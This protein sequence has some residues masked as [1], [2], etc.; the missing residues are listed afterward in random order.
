MNFVGIC[1]LCIF[2]A[3]TITLFKQYNPAFAVALASL[4]AAV[5]MLI[6][7]IYFK[8]VIEQVIDKSSY[9]EQFSDFLSS[10]LKCVGITYLT[11]FTVRLCEE[12]GNK[13]L[14]MIVELFGKTSLIYICLPYIS[15]TLLIIENLLNL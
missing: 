7:L 14:T 4:A 3:V 6:V 11:D 13:T 2:S 12:N 10:I 9:I 1:I 8:P 5:L 15:E